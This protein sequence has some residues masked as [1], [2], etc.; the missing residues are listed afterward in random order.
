M[1]FRDYIVCTISAHLF[2]IN[3]EFGIVFYRREHKMWNKVKMAK[4]IK[5]LGVRVACD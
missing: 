5:L 1:S 4:A 2:Y 3:S